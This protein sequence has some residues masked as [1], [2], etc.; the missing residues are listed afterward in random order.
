MNSIRRLKTKSTII[1]LLCSAVVAGCAMTGSS[2]RSWVDEQTAVAITAQKRAMVFYHENFQ[3]GVNLYDFA[4]LG[5]F[6]INQSGKRHQY[7]CLNLWSTL[8]RTTEQ[9]SQIGTAFNTMVIWADDQPLTFKRLTQ[10]REMVHVSNAV[11]KRADASESYYE[12]SPG[13]LSVLAAAKELRLAPANQAQG[14]TPYHLW[15]NEHNSLIAFVD[16]VS[17]TAKLIGQ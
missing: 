3:A 16:E 11:F 8:S 13:Q 6:E 4:D 15:R 14:E 1:L 2:V 5:A 10:N 7:L 17:H 12:I 9:Q